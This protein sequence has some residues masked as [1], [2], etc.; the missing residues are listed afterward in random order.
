MHR[1]RIFLQNF[2]PLFQL[3]STFLRFSSMLLSPDVFPTKLPHKQFI[4]L[5]LKQSGML[6]Y[7][8]AVM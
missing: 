4:E 1:R 6:T 8:N 3:I 7:L 2:M 5:L